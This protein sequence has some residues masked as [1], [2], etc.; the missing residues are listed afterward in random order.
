MKLKS[1]RTTLVHAGDSLEEI[2]VDSLPALSERAIV[3]IASKVV[4]TCENRFVPKIQNTKIEKFLLVE[5]ESEYYLPATASQYEVMLT[6][7][8][9]WMFAN[10][11]ID[12]SNADGKFILWPDDPQQSAN[13]IWKFLRRKYNLHEVGVIITDSRSL[14]LNWGVTGHAIVSCGF[15]PLLSYIG[16]PDLFGRLMKMEQ[17]NVAQSIGAA[18]A[19]VMG[20]GAEQTP[21]AVATELPGNIVFC[22]HEPTYAELKALHID[23][24]DDIYAP[25]LTAVSWQKGGKRKK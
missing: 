4:A 12:E 6:I 23:I 25:L 21:V 13:S 11:G 16:K 10:A 1:Y 19:L 2:L 17:L 3:V 20:E 24:A 9:N 8:G 15:V 5:N 22:D 7:K 14:P 18:A